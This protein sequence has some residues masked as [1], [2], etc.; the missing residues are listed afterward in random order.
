MDRSAREPQS[1]SR[2]PLPDRR[3][4]GVLGPRRGC[5][6]DPCAPQSGDVR[7]ARGSAAV[8]RGEPAGFSKLAH[9]CC[10]TERGFPM[11]L[12]APRQPHAVSGL[13][14][15]AARRND[16][17]LRDCQAESLKGLGN[18]SRRCRGRSFGPHGIFPVG[19]QALSRSAPT[20]RRSRALSFGAQRPDDDRHRF[21]RILFTNA[22]T[23]RATSSGTWH[24]AEGFPHRTD[25]RR[26]ARSGSRAP[27]GVAVAR[28][29]QVALPICAST[30]LCGKKNIERRALSVSDRRIVEADHDFHQVA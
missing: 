24:A 9:G 29:R 20:W 22:S 17:R 6:Q 2:L 5:A 26:R 4:S 15:G 28:R 23:A 11:R 21:A 16:R 3:Y 19:R 7:A 1:R 30:R 13:K 10:W 27:L 14:S 25:C 8:H 12:R 18:A